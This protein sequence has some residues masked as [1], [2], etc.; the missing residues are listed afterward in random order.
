MGGNSLLFDLEKDSQEKV[1]LS[2]KYPEIKKNT[3][4]KI[5]LFFKFYTF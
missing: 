1:D 2:E 5:K 4:Q 3:C